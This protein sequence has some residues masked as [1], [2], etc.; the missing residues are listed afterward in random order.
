MAIMI[1][2]SRFRLI[3]FGIVIIGGF[4]ML[5]SRLWYLQ[6]QKQEEYAKKLPGTKEVKHRFPGPRGRILDKNGVELARN[7]SVLQVG[8]DLGA[9][10]QYYK[11]TH[12]GTVPK[13]EWDPLKDKETDIVAIVKEVV[14]EPLFKLN[15]AL[16]VHEK[17][18]EGKEFDDH[19]R[20]HYRSFKGEV[21]F[22]YIRGVSW[23]VFAKFAEHNL[24]LP[25]VTISQRFLREYPFGA[26]T[27]HLV[28]Y[29]KLFDKEI[30]K[31]DVGKYKFYEGDDRGVAGLEKSLDEYLRGKPGFRTLL[32]NEHGRLER[33][34]EDGFTEARSGED[35]YLTID[36]RQQYIAETALREGGVGRGAVVVQDPATGEV[37]SMVAVPNFDPNKFI[38]SISKDNYKI[39]L[40]DPT[41]PLM[42]RAIS[43]YTPGS[44][45]KVP[46]A[47]AGFLAPGQMRSYY[48]CDGT[49]DYGGRAFPCWT[50]QKHMDSHGT[51]DLIG[52]L[53]NSCNCYFYQYGNDAGIDNIDKMCAMLGLGQ[54]T[55]IELEGERPGLVPGKEWL[56][57]IGGGVW[58]AARTANVSIGQAEVLMSPL[59]MSCAAATVAN[60]G[61]AYYPTL[62]HHRVDDIKN[63]TNFKPRVRTDLLKENIT[64]KQIET[65]RKG[66][67]SVVNAEHGTAAKFKSDIPEI[68][69]HG[70]GAGKTG[71]A[72]VWRAIPG[73]RPIKDNNTWF[74]CFAPYDT[75]K[76]AAAVM[77]QG[78]L[79][80]GST[81]APVAK[82]IIEQSIAVMDGSYKV[83]LA[84]IA[85]VTEVKG[86]FNLLE[87]ISYGNEP[88]VPLRPEDDTDVGDDAPPDPEL[89]LK[90]RAVPLPTA[91]PNE[92]PTLESQGAVTPPKA[93]IVEES[94]Y[95]T[96]PSAQ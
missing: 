85:K 54:L 7:R 64:A 13:F 76:V 3:L 80:G 15:L 58:G 95:K 62:I 66:M 75:P 61:K 51:I 68:A 19:L 22:T 32:I 84:T 77:V 83:D 34:I 90:P 6:F 21:P 89:V 40:D 29:V 11:D 79:S 42:N 24:N 17:A 16:D 59:Q 82:R 81:S 10:V 72:Q 57:G 9:I 31:E 53:K 23:E 25:G 49:V 44:T 37:L 87:A 8:L 91:A 14:I 65:V 46:V 38:P 20:V 2:S 71:T 56:K 41:N 1:Q 35:V 12:K 92:A 27:G 39:Y 86:N 45:F 26:L 93:R 70:G 33:E 28:G 88:N 60:G 78:G 69:E 73:S 67:W 63:T 36:I 94:Q 43:S 47:L 74:I 4:G 48:S 96:N 50:M 18:K 30:P 5:L 52:G 55:G